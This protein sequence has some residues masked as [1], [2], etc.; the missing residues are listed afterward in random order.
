[1]R[2]PSDASPA[3]AGEAGRAVSGEPWVG[4]AVA[5]REDDRLLRG[6]GAY[7]DDLPFP[8][9]LHMVVVRSPFA[10]A[11]ILGLD[12]DAARAIPGVVDVVAAADLGARR[13][14][15]GS[16]AEGAEVA[17]APL[18]LLAEGLV[19][20]A[21]E[22]VAAVLAGTRAAAEDAA[23]LVEVD[24][25]PLPVLVDPEAALASDTWLHEAA[26]GNALLRWRRS[27]GDVGGALA[28]AAR[29]VRGRFHIPRLVAAP[30]EPRGCVAAHDPEHDVL[31]LWC[32]AQDPHR[33]LAHLSAA[34]G[35]P[36]ERLRV[37]VPEVGGAFGSKGSLA[38]EHAVA[39][40]LALRTGRPVK[41]VEDRRENFL[42]APQG[43]GLDAEVE[44]AVDA[45]GRFLAVRA[46]LVAD[47]GA[48]LYANSAIV[49][50][51][52]AMLLTGGYDIPAAEVE[53][54]GVATNKVPTAPYR[55]A[56]RPEAAHL[57]ER[58][59]DLAAADLGLDPV[60]VRRRNA[61]P[62]ERFPHPT[63]LGF[64]YDSG[65][66]VA[67]LD[68]AC[69]LLPYAGWRDEQRAARGEGRVVGIGVA[70][71]IERA[72]SALWESADVA[73]E[74]DGRLVVRT[75]SSP[76][77]QGHETTF[78]QIAADVFGLDPR[79]VE[80]VHGD[81]AEVPPGVGTFGSRSTTVGG[82]AIVVVGQRVRALARAAAA[83][84]LEVPED[85]LV[86]DAGRFVVAGAQA[87]AISLPE[88]A[89]AAAADPSLAPEGLRA[90]GRFT[91]PG[92]VFPFAVQAVVVEIDRE[93][94]VLRI[95]RLVA[96]D[97]AG[98][99]VNPRLAEGQVIGSTVQG[100]AA[101]LSEEAVHDDQGQLL[102]GSFMDYGIPSAAD[103]QV[104]LESEFRAT[105]SPLNPLGAKGLGESGTIAAPAALANA[106]ADALAP[107][108]VTHLDP[109][110]TPERLWRVLRAA[111]M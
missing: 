38:P 86:W 95:L 16:A 68:R 57:V 80:V 60:E 34:L 76:H 105:P 107:L 39:A 77:G 110:F 53:V 29:V 94:G 19:R 28:T 1:M 64:V 20:F 31:T 100:L 18:P 103:L 106:V 72:G 55:G 87:R 35:L 11:R 7:V 109:P 49:P 97:D 65:D 36:R 41:W 21:G 37:V 66:Y 99:V 14:L 46:R 5:R 23:E 73:L 54:V 50:V 83:R 2:R 52:T 88:V 43:R 3:A 17:D 61:V 98:T 26:P 70:L 90:S 47:L 58:M 59:A 108:G 4:R 56:G 15:P 27:G 96:V 42:G 8:E 69:A 33:P 82:S 32:S 13:R 79:D 89:V 111:R 40:L 45:D 93:T 63:P 12:A 102:T 75:G 71:A 62:A 30:I 101:A 24:Y 85:D 67:A 51:T 6:A 22:P 9:A 92:P 25:D 104:R 10:H 84:L 81:S 48:Y 78:A 91:L 74:P 44:L